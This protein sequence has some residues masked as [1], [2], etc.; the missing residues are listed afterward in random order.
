MTNPRT[1]E[2][3]RGQPGWYPIEETALPF[4][5]IGAITA[6]SKEMETAAETKV[7]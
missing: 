3:L 4:L 1:L 2:Q 7:A 6:C 5:G